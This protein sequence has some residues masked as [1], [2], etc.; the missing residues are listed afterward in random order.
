MGNIQSRSVPPNE[1]KDTTCMLMHCEAFR[2]GNAAEAE[3]WSVPLLW[4][5]PGGCKLR[6]E[7][8]KLIS[9]NLF[10]ATRKVKKQDKSEVCHF[11]GERVL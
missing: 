3:G 6:T 2:E 7:A 1:T 10:S 5:R 8:K 9:A 11:M 4:R